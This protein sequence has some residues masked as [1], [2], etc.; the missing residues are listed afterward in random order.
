MRTPVLLALLL[1]PSSVA[2]EVAEVPIH[3]KVDLKPGETRTFTF[4]SPEPLELGWNATQTQPCTMSCVEVTDTAPPHNSFATNRGG[5]GKYKPVAGK[6]KLTYANKSTQAVTITIYRVKRTC[7]SE[8]CAF[9]KGKDEGHSIDIVVGHFKSITTSKDGSYSVVSGDT[10]AG[11]PFT[12][13]L[14]WWT[15]D[16]KSPVIINCSKTIQGYIDKQTPPEEY[17][18]YILP[19]TL[20]GDVKDLVV[21]KFTG[22]VRKGTKY[23]M[24]ESSIYK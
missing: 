19:G 8:S 15:D 17:S 6:I 3:T 10:V 22:C 4:Q 2:A 5:R 18:P 1:A 24:L 20:V 14:L 11:R 12:A 13:K 23:G 16:P 9:V 7:E 21:T